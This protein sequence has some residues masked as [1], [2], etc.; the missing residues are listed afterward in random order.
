MSKFVVTV[1][2]NEAEAYKGSQA[3][4]DLH[5]DG[6]IVLFAGAVISKDS[7]GTVQIEETLR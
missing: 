1:F 4:L 6:S 2:K 7:N 5:R 3:M